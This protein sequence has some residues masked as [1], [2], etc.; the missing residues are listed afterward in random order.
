M[1]ASIC[2]YIYIYMNIVYIYN[3]HMNTG[4]AAPPHF[5]L[6][7]VKNRGFYVVLGSAA[8]P[9]KEKLASWR[10]FSRDGLTYSQHSLNIGP[11]MG[12]HVA[13]IGPT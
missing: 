7:K 13:N 8:G 11:K 12:Q 5:L 1:N 3:I 2:G 10:P 9:G 4:V 6:M